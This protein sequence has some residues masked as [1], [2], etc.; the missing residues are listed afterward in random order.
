[1]WYSQRLFEYRPNAVLPTCSC[2]LILN[3]C[4]YWPDVVFDY[5]PYY[6]NIIQQRWL[7]NVYGWILD[8]YLYE[9][10]GAICCQWIGKKVEI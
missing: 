9:G 1:M 6:A 5:N 4:Q 7:E 3:I 8:Q 10:V 2:L